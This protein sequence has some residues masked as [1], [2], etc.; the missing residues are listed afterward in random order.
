MGALNRLDAA[1]AQST[2]RREQLLDCL[3]EAADRGLLTLPSAADR[4]NYDESMLPALPRWVMLAPSPKPTRER[5]DHRTH[6]WPPA[7]ARLVDV[8][9]L[10]TPDR[11]LA[12]DTWLKAGGREG[13]VLSLRERSLEIFGDE[14]E[15][16][17]VLE[18]ALVVKGLVA[19]EVF[20][21][22][23]DFEPLAWEDLT[24]GEPGI[25]A[26]LV[27]ENAASWRTF[28][29]WNQQRQVY[30][31]VIYGRGNSFPNAWRDL[32]RHPAI[33]RVAAIEYFGDIDVPG[34]EIPFGPAPQIEAALGLPF[35]LAEALYRHLLAA[36]PKVRWQPC[37]RRKSAVLPRAI[38]DW[39]PVGIRADVLR[40]LD[41]KRR[42][43]QEALNAKVLANVGA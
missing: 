41:S 11:W 33:S 14:K 10:P 38:A 25:P 15:L 2:R 3:S 26:L 1:G 40:V 20:H 28:A 35:R 24:K 4:S 6:P 12:V 7:L 19:R 8:P 37:K 17:D 32:P 16:I 29:T 23:E 22:Y 21:F 9:R 39:L 34:L 18:S 31:S 5:F 27:V 42:I 13:P 36:V 30:A 43:A